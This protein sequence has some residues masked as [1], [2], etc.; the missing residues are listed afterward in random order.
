[1]AALIIG[2]ISGIVGYALGLDTSAATALADLYI[3]AVL[4]P[5]IAISARRLHDIGLSGLWLLLSFVPFLGGIALLELYCIDSQ[6]GPNQFG[7]NPKGIASLPLGFAK[8]K[9][10]L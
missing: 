9:Q 4:V 7:P 8:D 6:P 2:F 10:P 3:L 5:S 1:M